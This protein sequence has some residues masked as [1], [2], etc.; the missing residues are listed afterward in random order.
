[1]VMALERRIGR[2]IKENKWRYAGVVVLILVGS[3]Y[4]T[5]ATGVS[6]S[7]EKMVRGFAEKNRQ[8]DLTFQ[9]DRPLENIPA[10]EGETGALIEPYRQCDIRLPSGE[11]RL[12]SA[13]SKINIPHILSGRGLENPGDILLDP[14][15][16]QTQGLQIGGQIGLNGK[17]FTIAGTVAAPNYV[18]I[19]E[20]LYDVL[21]TGGFGIGIVSGAD[22]ETFA[23]TH[24]VYAAYFENRDTINAQTA[25]LHGILRE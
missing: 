18:Y 17:T 12:L 13:S 1:M 25:L 11:L 5:A 23:E 6:G 20:N 7:L 16:C 19:I 9:T 2:I 22:I 15:F 24:T 4:F 8:E 14:V 10:L 21:Q 3:F